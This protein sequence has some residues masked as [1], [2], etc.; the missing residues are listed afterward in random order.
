MKELFRMLKGFYNEN[1]RLVIISVIFQVIYSIFETIVIP[2]ILA[3]T[4]NNIKNAK[5]FKYNI[6]KLVGCWI[7]IKIVGAISLYYHNQIEP[8]IAK[9]IVV[10]IINSIFDKYEKENHIT[11]ISVLIDKIHMIKTNLHDF[12]FIIFTIFIPSIITLIFSCISIF[13]INKQLGLVIFA[14]ILAQYFI[15]TRGLNECVKTT[16][17]ECK[18]RD[19][20]YDYIEDLF[21]NINTI[22]STTNGFD[23]EMKK[24]DTLTTNY[25]NSEMRTVKCILTKQYIG[26]GSSIAIFSIILYTV[27][28]LYKTEKLSTDDATTVILLIIGLFDNMSNMSYYMPEFTHRVGILLSN[29]DFLKTLILSKYDDRV[30]LS[31]LNDYTIKFNNVS[32]LYPNTTKNILNNLQLEIPKNQIISIYGN[33]GAGKTTFIKLIF[34]IENPTQGTITIGNKNIKEYEIKDTRKYIALIDQNTSN[35]F[36]RSIFDNI[37]YGNDVSDVNKLKLKEEIKNT[38]SK[39]NLYGIFKSLDK[40]KPMWSF[41]DQTVGKLGNKLSGGQKKIIHLLRI[42]LNDVA[43]IVILDEPSN[44]LDE[45]TRNNIIEYI[46]SMKD[47]GKTVLIITHDPYF[48]GISDKVLQFSTEENPKYI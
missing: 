10:T 13:R 26:S 17:Q 7:V 1:K 11:N 20:M 42:S 18:N 2:Y 21:T 30:N 32:F 29:E 5:D 4:F 33:S 36:N 12:S 31:T 24:I 19:G 8:Q 25:R 47:K 3:G 48:K 46:K 35:L 43:K 38:F 15:F 41:L 6:I 40:D 34:G 9:Y 14:C 22:Q 16:Y 23:S 28:N 39:F 37:I 27:Y 45:N 44:G